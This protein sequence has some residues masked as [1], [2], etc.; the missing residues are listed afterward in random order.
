MPQFTIDWIAVTYPDGVPVKDTKAI[1]EGD[2]TTL[3]HGGNGYR[4][5]VQNAHI[6]IFF[7]GSPGMGH[8]LELSSHGLRQVEAQQH[9]AGWPRWFAEQFERG[10][11][12]T[13]IDLA[14]DDDQGIV[15]FDTIRYHLDNRL[16]TTRHRRW[17]DEQDHNIDPHDP[18]PEGRVIRIGSRASTKYLRIYDRAA[19]LGVPGPLIRFEV[20]LKKGAALQVACAI[21]AAQDNTV[22][23]AFAVGILRGLIDFRAP[24]GDSNM[25]RAPLAPW[26]AQFCGDAEK[27]RLSLGKPLRT[28]EKAK[29]WVK[30]QVAPTLRLLALAGELEERSQQEVMDELVSAGE[31]RLNTAHLQMLHDHARTMRPRYTVRGRGDPEAGSG[32]DSLEA[33]E[34]D[35][36]GKGDDHSRD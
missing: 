22:L 1:F 34:L 11:K 31:G 24:E 14:L 15:D 26:W 8:H 3:D 29:G 35:R 10:A 25:R 7:D 20:E 12:P 16:M 4:S 6:R 33:E 18:R 36:G 23:G 13:R 19:R 32:A 9:F 17:R 28:I 27:V 30:G 5:A 21:A 2:W